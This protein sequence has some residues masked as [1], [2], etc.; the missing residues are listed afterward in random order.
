MSAETETFQITSEQAELH[1][2]AFVPALFVHWVGPVLDAAGVASGQ[3]VLDV[4]CGTGVATRGAAERVGGDGEVVGLD[5]NPVMLAVARR[6]RP[7]LVWRKGDA[8]ALPF[9]DASF[10]VVLSQF[11]MMFVP[12]PGAALTEM[13][14][15]VRP[16]GRVTVMVPAA[17]V[18]QPAFGPFVTA[19]GR[20]AGP[21]AVSMVSAYWALGNRDRLAE[22]ATSAGLEVIAARTR[23]IDI[24]YPSLEAMVRTE[25]DSTPLADRL[26]DDQYERILAE[27]RARLSGFATGDGFAA[28]LVGHVVTARPRGGGGGASA[29][30]GASSPRP[31]PS[32]G[33]P[34]GGRATASPTG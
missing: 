12:D 32:S 27:C 8:M 4:G 21:E 1:E 24:R 3:R 23:S 11:A 34:A 2:A 13:A 15:V 29:R 14:R 30:T 20:H 17:A 16:A 26:R 18:D 5:L 33:S 19:V 6:L 10:D 9:P 7:D 31:G 25:V 28:P 22:L